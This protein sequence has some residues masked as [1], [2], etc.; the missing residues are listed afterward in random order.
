[1]TL[2]ITEVEAKKIREDL[3]EERKVFANH[4]DNILIGHTFS[5]CEH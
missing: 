4:D 2:P 5:L 1:M 3:M